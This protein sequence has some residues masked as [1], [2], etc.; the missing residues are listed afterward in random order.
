MDGKGVNRKSG[1]R[2]HGWTTFLFC[3]YVWFWVG[4]YYEGCG[5]WLGSNVYWGADVS[6][7]SVLCYAMSILLIY[8][9]CHCH[10][11]CLPLQILLIH[12]V[13]I[14]WEALIPFVSSFHGPWIYNLDASFEK[15]LFLQIWNSACDPSPRSKKVCSNNSIFRRESTFAILSASFFG[16]YLLTTLEREHFKYT[17]PSNSD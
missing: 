1:L 8:I 7:I 11:N 15:Q 10:I 3:Q 16:T 6:L 9:C 12:L 17:A 13:M 4:W 5:P 14:T 2:F